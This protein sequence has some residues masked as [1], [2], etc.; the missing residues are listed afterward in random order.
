MQSVLQE[1]PGYGAGWQNLADWL[2]QR[3]MHEEAVAAITNLRR[4]EPL[5]PVPLG[6]R[7]GM[8]LQKNDRRGAK[9]DLERALKYDPAYSFASLTL[10]DLQ[11][12]DKDVDG[13]RR[14]F[15]LIERYVGGEK[16]KA[17]EV[18]LRAHGLKSVV[19]RK[20]Y[21]QSEPARQD[22]EQAVARLK[23]LCASG[24][25]DQQ[26]ID[27]AINALIEARQTRQVEQ[28]LEEMIKLPDANPAVG[29]WWMRR[30]I[31]RRKWSCTRAVNQLDLQSFATRRAV[32]TLIEGLGQQ[33]GP[34]YMAIFGKGWSEGAGVSR[35]GGLRAVIATGCGRTTTAGEAWAMRS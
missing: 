16:A 13:A 23:E 5:N 31:A 15:E 21:A 3:G 35:C 4:L 27:L 25:A 34:S 22:L 26:T 20:S 1:N 29:V 2:W 9:A 11:L 6:Y 7:A 19:V 28:V 24:A 17:C 18:K 10:F 12:A 14:T 32:T 33:G 30:R 8:K